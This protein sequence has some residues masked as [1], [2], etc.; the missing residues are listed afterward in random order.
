MG[1]LLAETLFAGLCELKWVPLGSEE[2]IEEELNRVESAYFLHLA[3]HAFLL[4][5]SESLNRKD[6]DGL[7]RG[8]VQ[9]GAQNLVMT[10]W[11]IEDGKTAPFL[12]DFYAAASK[13]GRPGLALAEVQK[14]WLIKLHAE[15]GLANACR[16]AGAFILSFQGSY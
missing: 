3:T 14:E 13:S 4:P 1:N 6:Q 7:R 9:A 16:V 2:A 11:P 15:K 10:L 12:A 8:F 5:E